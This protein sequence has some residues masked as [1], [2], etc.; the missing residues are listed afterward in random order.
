MRFGVYDVIGLIGAGG[1]GEVYRARDT[2][3]ARDVAVKVLPALLSRDPARLARLEREARALAT[4]SHPNIAVIHGLE[5]LPAAAPDERH[6]AALVMELV[7]GETLADRIARGPLALDEAPA[8]AERIAEALDTAHEKGIVHRDLKPANVKFTADGVVK[9]LDFGLAKIVA[10]TSSD[11]ATVAADAT[12]IG[13]VLGTPAYMSPEQAQGRPVDKRADVWAFGVLLYEM[14]AGRRPF[15]GDS[16]HDTMAAVLTA[17]PDWSAIPPRV[18]PIV[19]HCLERDPRKRLRT[20]GDFRFLVEQAARSDAADRPARHLPRLVS[21]GLVAAIAVAIT[22]A[23]LRPRP[24][25]P[26]EPVRMSTL[27]PAGV[28]VTRGAGYA[29][30]VALSPDGRTLVIAGSAGDGQRLYRRPLDQLDATPLAGTERAASPFFSWDGAWIGFFADGRLK[31]V[32]SAGGAAVDI[33]TMDGPGFPIGADW[34]QDDRILFGY[35]ANGPLRAVESRGGRAEPLTPVESGHHPVVLPDGRTVLFESRGWI[36]AFDQGSNRLTRLVEGAFPRYADG[37]LL[38]ARGNGLFAAPLDVSRHELTGPLVP[39]VDGVAFE[40]GAT[41]GVRHLA[42]SRS[43]TLAYVPAATAHELVLSLPNGTERVLGEPQRLLENPQIS[44]DGTRVVVAARRHG[45]QGPDLWIHDLRSGTATRLTFDGGRA[46]VWTPDGASV[47]Y[48]HTGADGRGIVV[49]RGDGRGDAEQLV[50]L[51]PFHWLVGW[52]PDRRTLAYG[53]MDGTRS[54]IVAVADQ[55]SRI[56][57]GPAATW[58]GRLSPDG[59]WL[60]YYSNDAGDFE[61][62]VTPFPEGGTRWL[63]AEGTDPSW[64]PDGRELYYRSGTRLM[65]AKLDTVTGVRALSHRV[66]IEPF[67]PPLYDDYDVHPDGRTLVLVRPA[68]TVQSREVI[69]VVNW[70]TELRRALSG[71]S[72]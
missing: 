22:W 38:L 24:S 9:V 40:A 30:S 59:R 60:A 45:D 5:E 42:L 63:I 48:S 23:W 3:L 25:P 16:S 50:P 51:E 53:V 44:P 69:V 32:P 71:Q 57:V 52:T 20:L 65:A 26:P 10:E 15:R 43:G 29:A 68:G 61:I 6:G 4:L 49:K 46:P 55:Q 12:G 2:R 67:L 66:V 62:Y 28:S 31:R 72:P 8:I 39:L 36:H 33:A 11:E 54:S 1:M 35:G 21:L 47:T 64:G 14:L 58:G 70:I 17:E 56:V 19:R 34:G 37:H 7:D 41:G 27:L 18:Q 13:V